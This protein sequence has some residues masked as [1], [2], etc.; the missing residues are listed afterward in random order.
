MTETVARR[1]QYA[2]LLWGLIAGVAIVFIV[3]SVVVTNAASR[4][5]ESAGRSNQRL[6]RVIE[7]CTRPNGECYRQA[8][9]QRHETVVDIND[10]TVAAS[11]CA[12]SI[13]PRAESMTTDQL[14]GE[15]RSCVKD[16]VTRGSSSH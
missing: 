10:V 5:A 12:M 16:Q 15:I 9:R 2:W 14:Y 7:D 13:A 8:R 4:S 11:V 3:Y 1:R 6:L